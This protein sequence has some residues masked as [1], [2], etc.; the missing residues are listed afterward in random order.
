MSSNFK[1]IIAHSPELDSALAAMQIIYSAKEELGSSLPQA[2]LLFLGIDHDHQLMA[3]MIM[4]EWPDLQLVGCTTDGEFSS[5]MGYQEDSAVLLLMVSDTC[6]MVAR[7][8]HN[9][10]L[11]LKA[12]VMSSL[13]SAISDLGQKPDLCILF[14][15]VLKVNGEEI[16]QYVSEATGQMVPIV[17]GMSADRW[18]FQGSVQICNK[19][20]STDISPFLLISGPLDFSWGMESGWEPYG[21]MGTVTKAQGN[22]IYEINHKPALEF[23]RQILGD[24]AKPTLELPIAIHDEEGHYKCLRTSFENFDGDTGSVKYLGNV[25]EHSKVRITMVSRESILAGAS[26]A[27]KKALDGYPLHKHPALALCFSCSARRVMLGTRTKEEYQI[28][29]DAVGPTVPILGYY[30][31]GEICPNERHSGT[32][33]HNETFVA[34]LLG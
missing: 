6:R 18:Q 22:V 12:N 5:L 11:D 23:Y 20:C 34:I 3:D 27:M 31:Y 21:E 2:G 13:H 19:N 28:I 10:A 9:S 29:K 25:F 8:I 15:D 17:G 4:A 33:F 1:P 14:S 7:S 32:E 24:G 16:I 30:T 26:A